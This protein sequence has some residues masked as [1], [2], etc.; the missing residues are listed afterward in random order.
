M[1][2]PRRVRARASA[3]L[4]EAW[5]E[6][7]RRVVRLSGTAAGE[8]RVREALDDSVGGLALECLGEVIASA[9]GWSSRDGSYFFDLSDGHIAYHPDTNELEIVA[10][11]EEAVDAEGEHS[12][13]LAGEVNE[14]VESTTTVAYYDDGYAGRTREW[15]ERELDVR[16]VRDLEAKKQQRIEEAK[17]VAIADVEETLETAASAS[18]Q[19]QL[20]RLVGTRSNELERQ[21]AQRLVSLGI[22][23]RNQFNQV[24][25]SAYQEAIVRFAQSNGA[26]ALS[27]V[28]SDGTTLIEFEL[29]R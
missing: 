18:A 7:A 17:S 13:Q 23:G 27:V 22:R 12:I 6:V 16:K 3:L 25:A 5:E 19:A 11:F 20:E 1:C 4:D 2:N 9:A 15:A 24:L 26:E 14:I 21:A 8:A 28:Q 29:E 10:R